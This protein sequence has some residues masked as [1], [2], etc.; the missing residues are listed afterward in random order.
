MIQKVKKLPTRSKVKTADT[1]D[2]ASLFPDDAAWERAMKR[3]ERQIPGYEKFRGTLGKSA[4]SLAAALEFDM[5][6]ERLGER[7]GTYAFLKTAEDVGNSD[8]QSM[9]A[10]LVNASSR[11]AET[12]SFLRPELLKVPKRTMDRFLEAKELKKFR[13][14]LERL[15]R[16]R[17]HTLS[18]KEERLLAMQ[19]PVAGASRK[20]FNQLNNADLK[21]GTTRNE[22]GEVVELSHATFSALLNS[23]KRSVRKAAFHKFYEQFDAHKN[24]IAATLDGSIQNDVFQARA[25]GFDSALGAALF[26]DD[27]PMSVYD[28]LI[29][30]V[31]GILPSLY[32]YYE[33]RRRKLKLRDIHH[34]DTYVPI[35]ANL[36]RRR[37]WK[38][39]VRT[40]VKS[41]APLGKDYQAALRNGLEGRWCDR[42]ENQGKQSGAFSC[43]S[44][45][46]D[47][48]IL[49]NYQAEIIDHLFTLAHEAGHSMH[50]YYSSKHQPFPDYNYTIFV[51]EVASTFNEQLLSRMLLD[52]A[53]TDAE[54]AFLINHEIDSMRAT[55]IRQTMFA[56]FEK[57]THAIVENHEALTVDRFRGEYRNLLDLYFGPNFVIDDELS[58]ECLRIPHFYRA[59][60]VYKYATGM[61][62]AIALCDRV[63]NGGKRELDDYLGFL[64]GGCS[65]FPLELLRDAGADLE[66][67]AVVDAALGRFDQLVAELETLL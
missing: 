41:V 67:P 44:Y 28:N 12:A 10:R 48:Y 14:S 39:A 8:Y 54:R 26:E 35:L 36:E 57:I 53:K 30:S 29:H 13:R 18:E 19:G 43:G 17:K 15:V 38:D 25:R 46:G 23:G 66:Q 16:Y 47:P 42:Y 40:V 5:K 2:L 4:K 27:V 51:A 49:M 11:A 20:I 58:L 7:L 55:I 31:H 37:P 34:Y 21:F 59:F 3:W 63:S 64:K 45:D 6:F 50:S 61:S 52:Q 33:L 60:Y 1:W 24:T 56:E 65:K 62:A 9:Y 22:R 32:R